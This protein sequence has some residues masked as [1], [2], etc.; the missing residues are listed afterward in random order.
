MEK[1]EDTCQ[2][3]GRIRPWNKLGNG[4]TNRLHILKK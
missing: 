3:V 2:S 1:K 4:T